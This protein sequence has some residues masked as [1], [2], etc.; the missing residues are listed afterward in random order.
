M[1][2]VEFTLNT[3]PH[4]QTALFRHHFRSQDTRISVHDI[5]QIILTLADVPVTLTSSASR[6]ASRV[7]AW[8]P[9]TSTARTTGTNTDT[10]LMTCTCA[11]TLKDFVCTD[12]AAMSLYRGRFDRQC[13]EARTVVAVT[14]SSC[15][16]RAGTNASRAPQLDFLKTRNYSV[17]L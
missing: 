8:V 10:P 5:S 11:G 17:S 4:H 9:A 2:M 3:Q 1:M 16:V 7:I 14:D 13:S 6:P 15:V 12:D